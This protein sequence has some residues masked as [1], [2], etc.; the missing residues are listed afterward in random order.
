MARKNK[1]RSVKVDMTGVTTT[2]RVPEDDY[3][4]VV[5]KI[6]KTKSTAGHPTLAWEFLIDKGK[7]EGSRLYYNTS[8]QPQAL[9]NL[10]GVLESLG[11][12][13]PD[14][15]MDL[16]LDELQEIDTPV[17]CTVE[18]EVYDG[19]KKARIIDIFSLDEDNDDGDSESTDK[20]PNAEVKKMDED[21]L[22]EVINDHDLDV[23]LDD[24]SG[25][26]KK[27]T[28]VIEALSGDDGD[29][30]NKDDGDKN[31]KPSDDEVKEMDEDELETVIDE[32]DLD[33]D[34]DDFKG[35]KKK[36]KAVIDALEESGDGDGESNE[37]DKDDILDMKKK[38]LKALI[39]KE[40]L[41]IDL[42]GKIKK[43]R[44]LVI[45]ELDEQGM[46]KDDDD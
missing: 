45:E 37:Y 31:D 30:D 12:K 13:I 2:K 5:D 8:L 15:T 22:E 41:D 33:V 32:H 24:I 34:L 39:K 9:W 19:K 44:K 25:I 42:T 36:R 16:D 10:R 29:K 27:R 28:A 7:Y 40:E 26:K 21:E 18:H 11:Q 46:L 4:I 3:S 6:E 43:D 38:D 1:N 35:I 14:S 17:G 20:P 23:D